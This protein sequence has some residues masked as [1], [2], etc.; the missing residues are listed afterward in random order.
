[1]SKDMTYVCLN[2]K[3]NC[4]YCEMTDVD[5]V[6]LH[7]I[8]SYTPHGQVCVCAALCAWPLNPYTRF[9]TNANVLANGR[10]KG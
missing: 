5:N 4:H 2:V 9:H 6:V 8:C 7:N 10:K 1:M 3:E